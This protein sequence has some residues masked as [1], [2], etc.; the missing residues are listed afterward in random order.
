[1]GVGGFKKERKIDRW[2]KAKISQKE[3]IHIKEKSK[4]VK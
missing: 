3:E 1:L 2:G 4:R